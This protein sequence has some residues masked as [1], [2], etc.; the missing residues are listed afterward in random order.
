MALLRCSFWLPH[1]GATALAQG[2]RGNSV[3]EQVNLTGN[4]I[5]DEG[6]IALACSLVGSS[7]GFLQCLWLS[8]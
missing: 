3:L 5:G 1:A 4:I 2:L 7:K 6:V 8:R